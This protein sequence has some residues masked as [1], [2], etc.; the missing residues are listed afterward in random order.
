MRSLHCRNNSVSVAMTKE[1]A[2][3]RRERAVEAVRAAQA[4]CG[5]AIGQL[6]H[7]RAKQWLAAAQTELTE[8]KA[9]LRKINLAASG[10][11]P[12]ETATPAPARK[13]TIQGLSV[14]MLEAFQQILIADPGH[15]A[16]RTLRQHFDAERMKEV[17][18]AAALRPSDPLPL[19]SAGRPFLDSVR[20]QS[21]GPGTILYSKR[22]S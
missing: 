13:F 14:A 15:P 5:R 17:S 10:A 20:R 6:E 4:A 7:Q 19:R 12:I 21:S 22:M 8:A 3:Q 18:P 11:A 9:E 2:Q 16:I 1:E